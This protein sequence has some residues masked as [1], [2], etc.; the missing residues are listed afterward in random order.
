MNSRKVSFYS[1]G[2]KLVGTVLVP[3]DYIEG[4]R[5]AAVLICHG[6]F[7]IKEWVPSRWTPH[8]LAA[9]Y[10]CLVFDYRNLG[11]SEGQPG[12][13]VPQEEVR[14]VQNAVT[15]IQQQ[16]EVDPDRIGVLGWGLGGGVAISAAAR[17]ARI[18]AV[19]CA[20]GIANGGKYGQVG[21]PVSAWA[22]RQTEIEQDKVDRVL[23]GVSKCLARTH[24]LGRPD[25]EA[26]DDN[27]RQSWIASLISAV[28]IERAS[29]PVLL[30]IPEE[31]T[32]ASMQ[33]LY[34]FKPDE[35]VHKIAPRP[36][37]VV[38]ARE[39]HEFPFDHVKTLFDRA[40]EPKDLLVVEDAGH[41]DWIDPA[42]PAQQIYVPQ[43]VS[44]M[45]QKLPSGY[46]Q[47][48]EK[49]V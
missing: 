34:E 25:D 44:W 19:V 22:E 12:T 38:H 3:D 13:I 37:L 15:F 4:E 10:V 17:D 27:D 28:G 49:T 42:F 29:N 30:G 7:A 23:T 21:M 9:G 6:R 45:Q 40:G 16:D 5:R 33:A 47:R 39:D 36:L 18:K 24:V 1:D 31:I 35:E 48:Y 11:E 41:L 26:T 43:V 8:F 46:S 20:S 2:I 32:L 14:D